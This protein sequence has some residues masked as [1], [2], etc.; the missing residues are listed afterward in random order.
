MSASSSQQDVFEKQLGNALEAVV[1]CAA[2]AEL[3]HSLVPLI[4]QLVA[5]VVWRPAVTP[6]RQTGLLCI[7]C[8]LCLCLIL[9]SCVLRFST[10]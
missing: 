5:L 6:E 2:D 1:A 9:E 10:Q 8:R 3:V 4:D 7:L